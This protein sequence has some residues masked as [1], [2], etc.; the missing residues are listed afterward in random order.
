M[1]MFELRENDYTC[2]YIMR[3]DLY[4]EIMTRLRRQF[5]VKSNYMRS[6]ILCTRFRA[7]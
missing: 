6:T 5:P 4:N 7:P 2:I 1:E 3:F